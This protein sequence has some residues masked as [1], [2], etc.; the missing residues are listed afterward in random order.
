LA[1]VTV[2]FATNRNPIPPLRVIRDFGD[3]FN[4][5]GPAELRFGLARLV[6][7]GTLFADPAEVAARVEQTPL[8][9]EVFGERPASEAHAPVFG[10][11]LLFDRLQGLM[12]DRQRDTLIYVHGFN[13]TFHQAIASSVGMQ[14]FLR[15][16]QASDGRECNVVAFSWPSD[17]TMTPFRSYWKDRDDARPTGQALGRLLAKLFARLVDVKASD[18]CDGRIHLLCHSMGNYVLQ[19]ALEVLD[20]RVPRIPPLFHEIFLVAA[21]VDADALHEPRKLARVT[22]LAQRVTVY[23]H[24]KDTALLTSDLTKGHPERLGQ[25]GPAR[26]GELPEKVDVVDCTSV[27]QGGSNHS[28]HLTNEVMADLH[29][30]MRGEPR[31]PAGWS[32]AHRRWVL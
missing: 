4:A 25:R 28:Y 18:A 27:R 29:A 10:S 8:A 5:R 12:R 7:D 31:G 15:T 16:R 13:T 22:E 19:S 20:E 11:D 17:G 21:D 3:A 1:T 24:R 14:W 32:A 9:I 6:D 30:T 23:H 26:M 2:S